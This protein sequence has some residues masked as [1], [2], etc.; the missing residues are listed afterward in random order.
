[1]TCKVWFSFAERRLTLNCLLNPMY[2]HWQELFCVGFQGL[3][4]MSCLENAELTSRLLRAMTTMSSEYANSGTL[5]WKIVSCT[6]SSV[7]LSPASVSSH[8]NI[9]SHAGRR[10]QCLR[11][12]FVK[13]RHKN[14]EESNMSW[15]LLK[16]SKL[17]VSL[18]AKSGYDQSIHLI[19]PRK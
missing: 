10:N 4:S 19:H 11:R 16:H 6:P 13:G 17:N 14:F 7:A 5:L 8:S 3:A 18:L 2:H 9:Y 12:P 1:M 15:V